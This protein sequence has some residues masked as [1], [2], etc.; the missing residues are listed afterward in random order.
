MYCL[1]AIH[2]ELVKAIRKRD[3]DKAEEKALYKRMMD[4]SRSKS[5]GAN[6]TTSSLTRNS[7]NSLVSVI[8]IMIIVFFKNRTGDYW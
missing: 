3:Q 2:A 8:V 4:G 5:T 1:Q 7:T 6:T